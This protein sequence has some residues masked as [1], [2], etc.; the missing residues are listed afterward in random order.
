MTSPG[1]HGREHGVGGVGGGWCRLVVLVEKWSG[2][3]V[4]GSVKGSAEED[5]C[6]EEC[7]GR[8]VGGPA[9]RYPQPNADPDREDA[10]FIY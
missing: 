7:E 1:V 10:K 6:G 9:H 5:A 2:G 8:M 4:D 3:S